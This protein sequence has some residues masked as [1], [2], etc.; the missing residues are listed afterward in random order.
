MKYEEEYCLC[1]DHMFFVKSED[2]EESLILW[3][4][5]NYGVE[6]TDVELFRGLMFDL[7]EVAHEKGVIVPSELPNNTHYWKR[8]SLSDFAPPPSP[9]EGGEDIRA[10]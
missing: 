10:Y 4:R 1:F 8:I 6:M 7:L 9:P 5:D 3:L 2:D